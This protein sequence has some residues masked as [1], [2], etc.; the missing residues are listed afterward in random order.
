M[1]VNFMAVIFRLQTYT[2]LFLMQIV[3]LSGGRRP[4]PKDLSKELLGSDELAE[5]QKN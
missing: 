2:K 3:I 4:K 5:G 1:A